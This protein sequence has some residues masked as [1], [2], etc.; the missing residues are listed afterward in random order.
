MNMNA[1]VNVNVFYEEREREREPRLINLISSSRHFNLHSVLY[2]SIPRSEPTQLEMDPQT[3][4]LG[5]HSPRT[6]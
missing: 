2:L 3:E 6:R 4:P 1:N 5:T